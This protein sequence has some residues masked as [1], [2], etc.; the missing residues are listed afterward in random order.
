MSK[1]AEEA[2][3][4]VYPEDIV[5]VNGPLD[6][7]RPIQVD[8]DIRYRKGFIKG[9]ELAI[10][11]MLEIVKEYVKKGVRCMDQSSDADDQGGYTF[12]DGFHNCA[13]NLLRELKDE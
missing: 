10:N 9:Y 2:S 3:M 13:E 8:E 12:W 5:T 11:G 7:G 6:G 1:R 4:K